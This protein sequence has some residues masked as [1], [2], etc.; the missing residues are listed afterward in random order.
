MVRIYESVI[1]SIRYDTIMMNYSLYTRI[2][3]KGNTWLTVVLIVAA[4]VVVGIA[5]LPP[6]YVLLKA[7]AAA[8]VLLP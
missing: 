5:L 4:A 3:D 8:Y 7:I 6:E 1:S 2:K